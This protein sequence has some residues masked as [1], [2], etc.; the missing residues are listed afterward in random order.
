MSEPSE[1]L[2]TLE[3]RFAEHLLAFVLLDKA[4]PHGHTAIER[5]KIGRQRNGVLAE[6]AAL[7]GRITTMVEPARA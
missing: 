2:P 4:W 5:A 1:T 3:Q 6:I 7:Q